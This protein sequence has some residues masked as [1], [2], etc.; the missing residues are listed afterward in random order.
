MKK[1][2]IR[3]TLPKVGAYGCSIA[4]PTETTNSPRSAGERSGPGSC[5]GI[6]PQCRWHALCFLSVSFRQ[7]FAHSA[8]GV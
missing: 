7:E 4:P 8:A 1:T 3:T 2:N 6:C 5:A